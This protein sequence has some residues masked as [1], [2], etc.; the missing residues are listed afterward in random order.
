M[1]SVTD[2]YGYWQRFDDVI[3][4]P[5]Y[6]T[7]DSLSLTKVALDCND[8]GMHHSIEPQAVS[9][10]YNTN[11]VIKVLSKEKLD[12]NNYISISRSLHG[13]KMITLDIKSFMERL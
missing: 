10:S 5:K 11:Y 1:L 3:E 13:L 6:N 4:A 12:T 8:F 2:A 9:F 7:G